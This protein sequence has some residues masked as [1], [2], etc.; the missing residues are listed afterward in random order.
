MSDFGF[1]Q[2]FISKD[3]A[4]A[5]NAAVQH[6]YVQRSGGI[7]DFPANTNTTWVL[8]APGSNQNVTVVLQWQAFPTSSLKI[9]PA[10][11][12]PTNMRAH[13]DMLL[14]KVRL[15]RVACYVCVAVTCS[16]PSRSLTFRPCS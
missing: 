1:S 8:R 3:P 7:Y 13:E 6:G 9:T 15:V 11:C 16:V 10:A 12:T 2:M 4:T 14:A 5:F